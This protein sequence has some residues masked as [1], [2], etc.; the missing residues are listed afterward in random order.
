MDGDTAL[1]HFRSHNCHL[2]LVAETLVETEHANEEVV[3]GLPFVR[4]VVVALT[5]QMDV[6]HLVAGSIE[7]IDI[8]KERIFECGNGCRPVASVADN[9]QG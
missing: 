1:E 8:L 9:L 3:V 5:R 4:S 6:T 2:T 7:S